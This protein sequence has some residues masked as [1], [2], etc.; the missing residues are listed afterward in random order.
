MTTLSAQHSALFDSISPLTRVR[1]RDRTLH[2]LLQSAQET[3]AYPI[4]FLRQDQLN[5]IDDYA[6]IDPSLAIS[7]LTDVE[8]AA[9]RAGL[10]Y[11]GFTPHQRSA[12][13]EWLKRPVAAAPPAF[14]TLYLAHLE[15][16]LF[17]Q[18]SLLDDTRLLLNYLNEVNEWEE[19]RSLSRVMLLARW[20]EQDASKLVEWL[21]SGKVHADLLGVA[22]GHVALLGQTLTPNMLRV[23]MTKWQI[24]D[25]PL[26]GEMARARLSSL[27]STL[28]AEP[29]AY[30]LAELGESGTAPQP[31]RS[32]HRE[33]RIALP[34]PDLRP[35]LVPHLNEIGALT[36]ST[37]TLADATAESTDD[38]DGETNK[39]NLVLEFQQSRSEYFDFALHKARQRPGYSQLMDENRQ[40]VYRITF[41]KREMRHFWSLWE[42]V[43][44]W[45]GTEVYVNGKLVEEWKIWPY[46]QYLR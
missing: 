1:N 15:T 2:A 35:L 31:W 6:Q 32:A 36:T 19:T 9:P 17:E 27:T 25:K 33:L 10:S 37:A 24:M 43:K 46:S 28:G 30:A 40:I 7:D 5:A 18:S 44:S 14:Q 39:W 11:A 42:Y 22:I 45:S 12:F 3:G 34:Q 8:P 20:L 41:L 38:D 23:L 26:D 16:C 13:L 4:H 29:L 21:E